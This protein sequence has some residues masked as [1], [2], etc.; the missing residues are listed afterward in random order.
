[1]ILEN[2]V[3]LRE[4]YE[5]TYGAGEELSG[6]GHLRGLI[7]NLRGLELQLEASIR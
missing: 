1:M 7:L 4:M 2:V 3:R 6:A 5:E